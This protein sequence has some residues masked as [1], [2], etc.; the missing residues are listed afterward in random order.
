[1]T[2]IRFTVEGSDVW[3]EILLNY[4]LTKEIARDEHDLSNIIKQEQ[5]MCCKNKAKKVEVID[6]NGN[7]LAYSSD[8]LDWGK[9]EYKND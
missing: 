9:L 4:S 6:D 2:K 7:L 1:M 5:D 3:H 8:I